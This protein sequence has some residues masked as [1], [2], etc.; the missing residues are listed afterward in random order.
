LPPERMTLR[1]RRVILPAR[2]RNWHF[3]VEVAH[4]RH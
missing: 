1:H 3:A 2:L 4:A